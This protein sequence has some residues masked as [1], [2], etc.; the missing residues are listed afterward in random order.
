LA[1]EEYNQYRYAF[2][3]DRLNEETP[4]KLDDEFGGGQAAVGA[5]LGFGFDL[6]STLSRNIALCMTTALAWHILAFWTLQT[7]D[8]RK[9]R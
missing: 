9:H 8:H 4:G 6:S 1:S 3:V 2:D 5:G 7:K